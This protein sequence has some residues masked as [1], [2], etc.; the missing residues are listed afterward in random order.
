M[1]ALNEKEYINK[2]YT[3]NENAESKQIQQNY[4]DNVGILDREQE[5]I[6]QQTQEN[7]NRTQVE[8]QQPKQN[9]SGN[10]LSFGAG[11]QDAL[12][13]ENA[14]MSNT[15]SLQQRE[16]ELDSEIQRQ[17][18]LLASQ[19]STAIK[20]AQAENDMVKAQQLYNAAKAE[21]AR[22]LSLR[23]QA[24]E[25][26]FKKGDKSILE[27]LLA[28]KTPT[29]DYSGSTWEQVLKNEG[30]INE[31]YDNQLEAQRLGIQSDY[32]KAIFDLLAKQQQQQQQTDQN[33]AKAYVDGLQKAKN[34]QEVQSAY[35]QGSGT[36][37][38]ARIAQDT[39]LQ[40]G[41]TKIRLDQMAADARFGADRLGM[42]KDYAD[43]LRKAL[44]ENNKKR[45]DELI[46][47]AEQEEENLYNAQMAMGQLLADKKDYTVLGK[48]YGLTD[49]QIDRLMRRGKY[50]QRKSS[51]GGSSSGGRSTN[52]DDK[53]LNVPDWEDMSAA[54]QIWYRNS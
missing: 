13:R 39:E 20:Q 46:K 18:Q 35:G 40:K 30:Q 47:A 7:I 54:D 16:N 29:A 45:S 10:R 1:N 11:Q 42:G 3:D 15:G 14:L 9:Y 2:L 32:E 33:L 22:L 5:R 8:A 41:M 48:L 52:K 28:G 12:N 19:F 37:G 53:E 34:Y 6:Q 27:E 43:K 17:R 50:A 51:G 21:E 49:D 36:A 23:Q 31:I 26:M 38:S 24:A 25:L 4:T 44:S